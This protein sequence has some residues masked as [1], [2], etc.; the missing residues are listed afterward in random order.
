VYGYSLTSKVPNLAVWLAIANGLT[1]REFVRAHGGGLQL[2]S[3]NATIQQAINFF[4]AADRSFREVQATILDKFAYSLDS[5]QFKRVAQIV[6]LSAVTAG[7]FYIVLGFM[8][9]TI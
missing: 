2:P 4:V 6:S 3:P 9:E 8:G 7:F 1:Y 5:Q